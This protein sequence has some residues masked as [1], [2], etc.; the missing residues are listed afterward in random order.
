MLLADTL[1]FPVKQQ[2]TEP[3]LSRF[4]FIG[5]I[6]HESLSILV[7]KLQ[8]RHGRFLNA[9]KYLECVVKDFLVFFVSD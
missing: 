4:T 8:A 7:Q 5:I 9:L 6:I 3:L 2:G 1:L